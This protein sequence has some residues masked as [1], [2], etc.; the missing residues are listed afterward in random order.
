MEQMAKV[1]I[2][3]EKLAGQERLA[4]INNRARLIETL[5]KIE[6]ADQQALLKAEIDAIDTTVRLDHERRMTKAQAA[7]DQHVRD[8]T[9]KESGQ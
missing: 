1:E 2:E 4:H 7:V 6:S 9:P 3:R 8:T 5:A